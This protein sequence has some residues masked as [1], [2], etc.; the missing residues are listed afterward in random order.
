MKNMKMHTKL[1]IGFIIVDILV[2]V[3]IWLGYST[4]KTIITVEN[5]QHYLQSYKY[6]SIGL[7]VIAIIIMGVISISMTRAIR[8]STEQ[9]S[10]VAKDISLGKVD[11]KLVKRSN[12]EFG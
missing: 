4:A 8:H 11:V 9:L 3:A 7:F 10:N 5:P 6:F 1:I 2:I 12:D